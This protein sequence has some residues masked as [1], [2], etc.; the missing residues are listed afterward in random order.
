MSSIPARLAA[1]LCDTGYNP[2]EHHKKIAQELYDEILAIQK[3][4][5]EDEAEK[6][7]DRIE[8]AKKI[9]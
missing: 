3:Y 7:L 9:R 8:E 2:C 1:F 6:A 5:R 4:E